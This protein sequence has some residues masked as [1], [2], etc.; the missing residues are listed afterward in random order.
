[1]TVNKPV[2]ELKKLQQLADFMKKN[3]LL[4]LKTPDGVEMVMDPSAFAL[5]PAD[6]G[7]F[8][9]DGDGTGPRGYV[10]PPIETPQQ[11]IRREMTENVDKDRGHV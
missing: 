8:E 2:A 5:E 1:M 11:R 4:S 9:E 3:R 7:G 6:A 10:D